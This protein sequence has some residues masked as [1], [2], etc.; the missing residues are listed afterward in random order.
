MAA[1]VDVDGFVAALRAWDERTVEATQAAAHDA[2][3]I[4]REAIQD[5][6]ARRDYPPASPEGEPPAWRTGWLFEHVYLNVLPTDTGWQAR[7]Y[8]S[9]VYARI[10][11]LSGWA[12]RDHASF[13]PER[14]Y[15]RPARDETVPR[16][17]D[18]FVSRW[19]G[20]MP[21]G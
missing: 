4:V 13:L 1:T 8:P 19:R 17:G 21:G 11:E 16:V 18:A 14:P 3:E 12:G 6:L 9:T 10:H 15:V 5:N 2:G 7:A 20:A